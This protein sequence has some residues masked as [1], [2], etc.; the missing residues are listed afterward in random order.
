[1]VHTSPSVFTVHADDMLLLTISRI[2][3]SASEM[4]SGDGLAAGWWGLDNC[5]TDHRNVEV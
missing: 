1:M 2:L 4:V 5:L 3:Y